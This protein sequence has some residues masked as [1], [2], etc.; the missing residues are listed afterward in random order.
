MQF[1]LRNVEKGGWIFT[2]LTKCTAGEA[3]SLFSAGSWAPLALLEA[4]LKPLVRKGRAGQCGE[5]FHLQQVA[6]MV[7]RKVGSSVHMTLILFPRAVARL[8]F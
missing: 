8:H 1:L 4:Y 7:R 3:H 6:C 5:D 2:R